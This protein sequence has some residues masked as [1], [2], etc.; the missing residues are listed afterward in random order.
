[1][2]SLLKRY[3]LISMHVL[4]TIRDIDH[5]TGTGRHF[6]GRLESHD[7]S[8]P[9]VLIGLPEIRVSTTKNSFESHLTLFQT[10]AREGLGPRLQPTGSACD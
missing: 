7:F 6:R 9:R 2:R 4:F 5:G 3:S 8:N 1:M 10:G